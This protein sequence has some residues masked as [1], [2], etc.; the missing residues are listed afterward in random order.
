MPGRPEHDPV[1]TRLAEP[2]VGGA[3]VLPDVGL[4]LDDPADPPAGVV[5]PDQSCAE[6]RPS[7]LQRR[8]GERCAIDEIQPARG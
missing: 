8:R 6:Q 3:I 7:G 4:D 2:G 5:V 1:A